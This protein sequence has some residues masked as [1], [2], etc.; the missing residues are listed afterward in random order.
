MRRRSSMRAIEEAV[1]NA[2]SV[3]R[4]INF[5]NIIT[6]K[7]FAGNQKRSRKNGGVHRRASKCQKLPINMP[8]EKCSCHVIMGELHRGVGRLKIVASSHQRG[9]EE[10]SQRRV[11]LNHDI[12]G[13]CIN[14]KI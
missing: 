9:S 14:Y 12:S 1:Q 4:A 2:I 3:W 7:R 13:Q 11:L 8:A 10:T 6:D 5:F